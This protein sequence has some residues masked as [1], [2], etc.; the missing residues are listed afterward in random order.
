M[1]CGICGVG[2]IDDGGGMEVGG[3]IIM[4]PGPPGGIPNIYNG[5]F[6]KQNKSY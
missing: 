3:G 1:G 5:Y 6:E 4:P 2:G